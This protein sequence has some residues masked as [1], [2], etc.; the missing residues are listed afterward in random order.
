[1]SFELGLF[2]WPPLRLARMCREHASVVVVRPLVF[3]SL[4]ALPRVIP[5]AIRIL[6][7]RA[8][9]D[10]PPTPSITTA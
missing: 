7:G 10:R 4:D 6:S 1:M 5:Q 9:C 2:W 3:H 8:K